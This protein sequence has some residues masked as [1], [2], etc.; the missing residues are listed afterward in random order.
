MKPGML[1]YLIANKTRVREAV[2]I[3]MSGEFCTIK[4]TDG[5]GGIRIRTD[6]LY[7]SKEEAEQIIITSGRRIQ[8]Y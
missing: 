3:K 5:H 2:I 7:S 4:F 8:R 6:R 1:V